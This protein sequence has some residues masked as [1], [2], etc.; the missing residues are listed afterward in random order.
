MI[1]AQTLRVY[2]EESRRTLFGIMHR[3]CT[4]GSIMSAPPESEHLDIDTMGRKQCAALGQY[5]C[6]DVL[7]LDGARSASL[8]ALIDL[9]T[10]CNM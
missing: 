3:A 7:A 6:R 10:V 5:G 2:G 8:D 4:N 1:A 9:V